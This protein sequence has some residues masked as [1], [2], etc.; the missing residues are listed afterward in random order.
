VTSVTLLIR[1]LSKV[2]MPDQTQDGCLAKG[3]N[4]LSD[5]IKEEERKWLIIR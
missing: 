5:K 2:L 4:Y 1:E 3:E